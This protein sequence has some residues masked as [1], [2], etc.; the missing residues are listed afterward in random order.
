MNIS[1]AGSAGFKMG[2]DFLYRGKSSVTGEWVQGRYISSKH[3]NG[4]ETH[5]ID[6]GI[7]ICVVDP[8]TVGI[9]SGQ[10]DKLQNLIFAGH[11][12]KDEEGRVGPVV[13]KNG[14]FRVDLF[15]G[16]FLKCNSSLLYSDRHGP[17]YFEIVGDA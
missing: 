3:D 11:L 8:L 4:S 13:F 2:K 16:R 7:E 10:K 9:Y 14:A 17:C 5:I 6:T 12:V 1:G 15:G